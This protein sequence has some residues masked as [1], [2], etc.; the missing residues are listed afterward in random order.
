MIDMRSRRARD[1]H[2]RLAGGNRRGT[3]AQ[4][5]LPLDADARGGAEVGGSRGEALR[6]WRFFPFLIQH[7]LAPTSVYSSLF[8]ES[9]IFSLRI[10]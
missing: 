8:L 5:G 4:A 3:L 9:M 1:S 10:S 2:S 6:Q 7:L